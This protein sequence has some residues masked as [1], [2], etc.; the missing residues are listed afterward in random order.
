MHE[1]A[2]MGPWY[3]LSLVIVFSTL[4]N[5]IKT[6]VD[7]LNFDSLIICETLRVL[8]LLTFKNFCP[9][10]GFIILG[11]FENS[12][13]CAGPMSDTALVRLPDERVLA[14]QLIHLTLKLDQQ[15]CQQPEIFTRPI[16]L[17]GNK[18][19]WDCRI[20]DNEGG[21]SKVMVVLELI[22]VTPTSHS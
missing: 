20:D 1:I 2:A 13:S 9:R 12:L 5:R 8:Y 17:G 10:E 14:A 16:Q 22:P 19:I 4:K 21:W 11:G 3:K 15:D 6:P 18:G 7:Q